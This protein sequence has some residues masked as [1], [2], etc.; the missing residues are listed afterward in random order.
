MKITEVKPIICQGGIRNWTLVKVSTDEGIVGWGDATEWVRVQSHAKV[1]ELLAPMLIGEDPF[2]IERIWQKLYVASYVTGKDL[3]VALSGIETALWDIV[4]KAL[5]TP[6]YNLLGGRCYDKIRLYYDYCDAYGEGFCGTDTWHKGDDSSEGII[7]QARY[8]KE[9]NFTALKLHPVGLPTRPAITRTASLKSIDDT[10]KKVELVR[11]VVGNEVEICIDVN[12]RLDVYSSIRLAK[13]LEPYR[14]MFL[15]DPV[16]QDESPL[17]YRRIKETTSTPIGTGENLYNVWAF[18]NYLEIGALDMVLFDIV[19]C[20]GILQARKIAALAE[21][22]HLP[23]CPHNPNS[24]LSTI[25]SAH[26]CASIPNFY[27]LEYY[28]PEREPSWRDKIIDPPLKVVDGY[29]E[30]PTGAGWGVKIIE[31]EV[32]RHPY[33]EMWYSGLSANWEGLKIQ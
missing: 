32:A 17:S 7:K 19:H 12:N 28:S 13:A 11:K 5:N 8:I 26:F 33:R 15:E 4:G 24:P 23:V 16:R 14:I 10:V 1:I 18:K 3:N 22:Y 25:I 21:A 2:N 20:G 9:Q 6:V 30:L 31:E 27:A 29:L